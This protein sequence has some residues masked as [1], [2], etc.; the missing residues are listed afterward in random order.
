MVCK[1]LECG[2]DTEYDILQLFKFLVLKGTRQLVDF[3]SMIV[4]IR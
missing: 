3:D 4:I 1:Y 2:A